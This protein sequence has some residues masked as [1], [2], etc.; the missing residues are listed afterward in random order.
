[1]HAKNPHHLRIGPD[2]WCDWLGCTAGQKINAA[3]GGKLTCESVSR[4]QAE[5][6]ARLLRPHFKRGRVKVIPGPCPHA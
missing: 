1:M 5:R 4:A 3:E 2:T 6:V